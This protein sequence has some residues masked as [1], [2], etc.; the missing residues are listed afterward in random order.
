MAQL[1]PGPQQDA[2][3]VLVRRPAGE[4]RLSQLLDQRAQH[5]SGLGV[6]RG[7]AIYSILYLPRDLG[8]R[9]SDE[10]LQPIIGQTS[11]TAKRRQSRPFTHRLPV[12]QF[13]DREV[14]RATLVDDLVVDAVQ[15]NQVVEA[16]TLLVGHVLDV[17]PPTF[18]RSANVRNLRV[19]HWNAIDEPGDRLV[20]GRPLTGPLREHAQGRNDPSPILPIVGHTISSGTLVTDI[21]HLL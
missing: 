4:L 19:V 18:I 6:D 15:Q 7:E 11:Q 5:I 20:A 1:L 2:G 14:V 12:L 21:E 13:L 9:T 16:V 3:H 8:E 10:L 17:A